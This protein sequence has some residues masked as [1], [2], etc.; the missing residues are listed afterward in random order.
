MKSIR[1]GTIGGANAESRPF[2][3]SLYNVAVASRASKQLRRDVTSSPSSSS[4]STRLRRYVFYTSH[5]YRGVSGYYYI[6]VR[7]TE[8]GTDNDFL[9]FRRRSKRYAPCRPYTLCII[10]YIIYTY[11]YI[12]IGHNGEFTVRRLLSEDRRCLIT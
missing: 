9:L 3:Y 5:H 4:S 6:H 1:I 8:N 11:T 12:L 2:R 7:R 10:I